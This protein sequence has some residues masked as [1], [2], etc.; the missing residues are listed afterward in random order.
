MIRR[1]ISN[2]PQVIIEQAYKSIIGPSVEYAHTVW[3][4]Y[5]L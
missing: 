3:D 5:K 2:T 1:N 4:P